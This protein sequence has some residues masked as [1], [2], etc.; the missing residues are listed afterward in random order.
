LKT[1]DVILPE[2][3]SCRDGV[4][5]LYGPTETAS[6]SSELIEQAQ[7]LLSASGHITH[8]GPH[9]TWSSLFTETAEMMDEWQRA[10]YLSVDMETATTLAVARY[11][12][13][14]AVSL[15]VV[16]D[17]LTR[18]RRFLDPLNDVEQRALNLGNARV[19]EVALTLAEYDTK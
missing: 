12:G 13:M 10:G 3:A 15:L 11:F 1:G 9:L 18:G 5:H 17:D 8:T 6:G 16:W 2:T 19:Y 14:S 7:Q 4:A